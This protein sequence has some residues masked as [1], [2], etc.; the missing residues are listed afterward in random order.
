MA[1]TAKQ[2]PKRS[3]RGH[4][5]PLGALVPTPHGSVYV[6]PQDMAWTPSQFPGIDMKVLYQDAERG[7]MTVLLRWQPGA[8]LPFHKHPEI[9]QS[10]VIEGSFYDHDGICRAGEFVYRH[11]QSKH[12][13][14]SDEGCVILAIYRKPNIF[15][16]S[17]AGFDT[18]RKRVATDHEPRTFK[19]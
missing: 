17:A 6:K 10:Y 2:L 5:D 4:D 15:R 1:I 8:T 7:E 16:N 14:R 9:E 3:T 18:D 19:P 13:T 12:E 11:P